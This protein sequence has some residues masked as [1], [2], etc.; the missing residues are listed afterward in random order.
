MGP[1]PV[2]G[3]AWGPTLGTS[4]NGLRLPVVQALGAAALS[5][6]PAFGEANGE[7]TPWNLDLTHH[8]NRVNLGPLHGL[9]H[10]S[11]GLP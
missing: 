9:R 8:L 6:G 11:G 7:G 2:V 10:D 5:F 3:Y 4:E 1:T